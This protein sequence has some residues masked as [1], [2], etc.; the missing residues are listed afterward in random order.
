MSGNIQVVTKDQAYCAKCD[1][2]KVHEEM[3]EGPDTFLFECDDCGNEFNVF[4]MSM[5][6]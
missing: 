5:F 6:D 1:S 3:K 2:L 4:V